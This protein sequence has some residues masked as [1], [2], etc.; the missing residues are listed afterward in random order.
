[1]VVILVKTHYWTESRGAHGA[2]NSSAPARY[3]LP[4]CPYSLESSDLGAL[5]HAHGRAHPVT[6]HSS[7]PRAPRSGSSSFSSSSTV[8]PTWLTHFPRPACS[9]HPLARPRVQLRG[10]SA[11]IVCTG[12][13]QGIIKQDHGGHEHDF[14]PQPP[15]K[16]IAEVPPKARAKQPIGASS[17]RGKQ[18]VAASV[19]IYE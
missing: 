14:L 18:M 4:T 11:P 13:M 16:K 2:G 9:S 8:T 19:G 1:M 12:A 3:H 15:K 6:T 10:V 5:S 17:L 7:T